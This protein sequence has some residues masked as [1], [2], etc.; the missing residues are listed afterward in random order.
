MLFLIIIVQKRKVRHREVESLALGCTARMWQNCV[1]N[2]GNL[3]LLEAGR[4]DGAVSCPRWMFRCQDSSCVKRK[5]E[6]TEE[7]LKYLRT[8]DSNWKLQ[9]S[10]ENQL[11]TASDTERG[12]PGKYKTCEL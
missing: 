12:H 11:R 7:R 5:Q 6:A 2:P 8:A 9:K 4:A 1:L 10:L 3:S